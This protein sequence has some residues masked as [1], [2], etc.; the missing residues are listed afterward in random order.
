LSRGLQRE[1]HEDGVII[2]DL[3]DEVTQRGIWRQWKKVMTQE[4]GAAKT[5]RKRAGNSMAGKRG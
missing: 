2:G 3:A 1:R 5:A 4:T